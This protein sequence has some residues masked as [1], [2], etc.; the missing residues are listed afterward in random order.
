MKKDTSAILDAIV[1]GCRESGIC[2]E[3]GFGEVTN[4]VA[5][6][7]PRPVRDLCRDMASDFFVRTIADEHLICESFP[8]AGG[9]P[10]Q[11]RFLNRRAAFYAYANKL[12]I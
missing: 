5:S 7:G 12:L 4:L 10:P 1:D 8:R 3:T 2:P 11:K 9:R 6:I